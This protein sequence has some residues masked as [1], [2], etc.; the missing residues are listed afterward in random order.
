MANIQLK[1]LKF[2]GL[3]DTY[4]IPEMLVSD[5]NND[6]NVKLLFTIPTS[7]ITFY[8]NNEAYQAESNMIWK[9]WINST[10]NT[11]NGLIW[12]SDSMDDPNTAIFMDSDYT[13]SVECHTDTIISNHYYYTEM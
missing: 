7:L 4:V 2:P 13:S 9:D 11:T 1:T 8:L 12:W 6:G 5:P 3:E 10:Y